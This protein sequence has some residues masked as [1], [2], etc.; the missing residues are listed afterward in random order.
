M[1]TRRQFLR[2][3]LLV[4]AAT[5]AIA[6]GAIG[7]GRR[8]RVWLFPRRM[9]APVLAFLASLE[10]DSEVGREV[11][12]RASARRDLVARTEAFLASAAGAG[13][14]LAAALRE[15]ISADFAAGRMVRADGWYL[16][17]TEAGV[18]LL[19]GDIER[20]LYRAT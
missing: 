10:I 15:Q 20:G 12:L 3:A 2:N 16:A 1:I 14:P 9:P 5:W 13:K 8:L 11:E 18:F 19:Q 7:L 4:S 6:L 17:E